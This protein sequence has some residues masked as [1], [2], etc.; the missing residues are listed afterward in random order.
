MVLDLC[1]VQKKMLHFPGEDQKIITQLMQNGA[2][3]FMQTTTVSI[4]KY[5]D[6]KMVTPRLRDLGSL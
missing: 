1:R 5:R 6:G 3:V 2:D 4:E